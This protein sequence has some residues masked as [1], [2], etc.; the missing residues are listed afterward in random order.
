VAINRWR[1]VKSVRWLAVLLAGSVIAGCSP[2]V[3]QQGLLG[4][5]WHLEVGPDYKSPAVTTVD[6]FRCQ[7]GPAEASSLADLPWWKIFEDKSLQDL[8]TQAL[9]NNYDLQTA[10]ARVQQARAMVWVSASGLYPHVGYQ[11]FASREKAFSPV[12]ATNGNITLNTFG[13]FLDVFW[14]IDLWGR[15]RR[16]TEAA[17]ANFLAQQDVRRGVM[18]TLVSD[19]ATGYFRLLELDLELSIAQQSAKTYKQTLDLFTQRFEAGRDSKLPVERAQA[20]YDSAGAVIAT[21]KRNIVQ[22]ENA[23]SVLVGTY[24]RFIDRRTALSEQAVPPTPVGLTTDL[25]RRRPDLLK[26]E[27]DMVAANAEVGVAVANFFPRIGLSALYGGQSANIED[28]VDESFSIW[29]IAANAAGPIFEGGRLLESY[30]AQQA[31][32]DSTVGQY[33]QTILVAFR[34]VSDALIAQQTLVDQRI[35]LEHQVQALKESVDLSLLRYNAGRS[36][37]FEVLEAEQLLFP[38]EDQLAQ[39][40]RDQLL[41]VVDLYKALG[42]GW[43]RTNSE[44]VQPE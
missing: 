36:S 23:L 7:T 4:K 40:E 39:T 34:E 9:A 10:A 11:G 28:V 6:E 5:L 20:A 18:L 8:L 25:V 35:A 32:F 31:F 21:L 42:G 19:V 22:Q 24:P 29:N 16:S 37:Y 30:H 12:D 27:D 14:E 3:E 41:A 33:K 43:N 13:G 38:A 26:A 17:R 15:V 44:W 2:T 1:T